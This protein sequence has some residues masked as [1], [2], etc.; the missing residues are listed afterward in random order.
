[1]LVDLKFEGKCVVVVGGGLE[2]V[3]KTT[4]FLEAGA[5]ILVISR[6]FSN[7]IK[8]LQ[9]Q[10]K[11]ELQQTEVKDAETL[12]SNLV[13]KP[14]LLVAVTSN[15][16]LNAQLIKHAKSAGCM[17]YAPDNPSTS[18][19]VLPAIA[20]I[21]DVRIA[22][23]TNGKSPA[24][25]SVIRKRIEKNIKPEDLL[26]VKLQEY[27]RGILKKG[28]V[29]QKTR[30][31]RLYSIIQDAAIQKLLK[32]GKFEEAKEKALSIAAKA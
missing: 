25:A 19:I 28:V 21:G 2:S 24:M 5:K 32:Q 29:D 3:R 10:K 6:S 17:V 12:V 27:M 1:M 26:Q 22:V 15:H 30:R 9:M 4:D 14:D 31:E 23:S 16:T 7:G 8:Q 20:K 18:D 13:P 11:I